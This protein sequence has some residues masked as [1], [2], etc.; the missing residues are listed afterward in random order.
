MA[1]RRW[2][3][4]ATLLP[5]GDR[6]ADLWIEAGRLTFSPLGDAEELAAPGGYALAGLVD[7]HV[8]LTLDFAGLG[9][10]LGSPA[11][12]A[13][14]RRA[15]RDA[16]VLLMRDIGAISDATLGLRADGDLPEVIPAGRF[17]APARGYFGPQQ[18]TEAE[19][20]PTAATGQAEHGAAW[21][22]IVA[23][24]PRPQPGAPLEFSRGVL[25][26]SAEAIRPAV[27]A[28][29]RAGARVAAHAITRAAVTAAVEAGV[30]S[31]EHGADMDAALVERMAAQG[32][33]WTPTAA[34]FRQVMRQAEADGQGEEVRWM[35]ECLERLRVLIP[36]AARLG[37]PILAGTD[38]FPAGSL[39]H[40][41]A[42]LQSMGLEPTQALAAATTT[43]RRFLDRPGLAEGSPADL[44]LYVADPRTDPEALRSPALIMIDG[45]VITGGR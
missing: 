16:G 31:V 2:H 10:P 27:E 22:K 36:H 38:S 33:A 41:I 1:P 42:T 32:T 5:E 34:V 7:S 6:P 3:L 25:N 23:D 8:H 24:W 14:N 28:A 40:E 37:V 13:A 12:V 15:Q 26:Y 9:Q 4:R 19:G 30:D 29:H 39:P 44:V 21:V 43:A 11:L 45:T 35:D 17:L 20:L 18:A